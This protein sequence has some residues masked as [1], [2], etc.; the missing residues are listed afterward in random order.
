MA[1]GRVDA[2]ALTSSG[3]VRRLVE[4]ARVHRCEDKLRA[5]LHRT[6][7]ASVGP[8]VSEELKAYGLQ[9]DITPAN[10]AFFIRPLISAIA[11]SLNAPG[12]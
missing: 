2:I 10:D 4:I 5:G 3:Q 8:V 6:R 9:T 12:G 11:A 7:I 1:D